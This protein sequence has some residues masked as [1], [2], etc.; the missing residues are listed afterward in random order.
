MREP[1]GVLISPTDPIAVLGLFKRLGA[2]T[3]LEMRI[4]GESLFNDGVGVALFLLLLPLVGDGSVPTTGGALWLLVREALGGIAFGAIAGWGALR[5]LRS[6][7][8]YRVEILITL[9]LVSGGFALAN[10]S[11]VSAALATVV[12]GLIVGHHGRRAMSSLTRH[13]L[14]LFWHL[15]FPGTRSRRKPDRIG[16]P[17]AAGSECDRYRSQ[18]RAP[19]SVAA[20]A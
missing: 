11:G 19:T 10:A 1:F 5:L 12:A 4:A 13:H 17:F 6:V 7:D 8:E 2:P 18:T 15:V 20:V 3:D 16:R 9:V 14:D